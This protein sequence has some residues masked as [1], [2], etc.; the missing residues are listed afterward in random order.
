VSGRACSRKAR[1]DCGV[2]RG[3]GYDRTILAVSRFVRGLE[4]TVYYDRKPRRR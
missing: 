1:D 4:I 2:L 3:P